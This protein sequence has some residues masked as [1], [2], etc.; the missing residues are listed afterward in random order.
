MEY[1][2]FDINKFNIIQD[3]ENYYFFRALNMADNND[4]EQG[5]TASEN[6]KIKRIRTD[7]E[8]FEGKT[9]YSKDSKISLEELYDHIKMHQRKDTNCISLT[10]NSNVAVNYGRSSYKDRYVMVKIPKKEFGNKT[11]SAGQFMLQEL[12]AKIQQTIENLPEQEKQELLDAFEII[13]NAKE[14]KTLQDIITRRY[15]AKKGEVATDNAHP[16]KG[17][18]YSSPKA[19]ISSYQALDEEQLLELNKV[20]AKLAI[21]ENEGILKHVIPHSTNSK[22]RETIGNAFSSTEVIHYGEIN[23]DNIIEI[24]K[25]IA[26]I[27]ALIQQVS[28]IEKS[29]IE[30]L[31]QALII[32]V[33]NGIRISQI[34]DI[35][36]RVKDNISIEEMYELT[37]GKV[38]YG[39]ANSIVKN[40]FYLSKSRQNAIVLS[41]TLKQLLGKNSGFEDIIEYIRD[42]GFRV[43]PEIISRKS[44]KGLVLSESVNL[45]L[46]D[47]EQLLVD[48]IKGLSPEELDIVLQNGGLYNAKDIIT[49]TF[50]TTGEKET[51]DKSRYYAEAIIARYNW[52][53]IGIEEF[54]IS[55]K[56]E[57]I[58]RLQERNCIEIYEK[59]KGAGVGEEKIPT[60]LLNIALR[61]TFYE[62]YEN[63]NLEELLNTRQ[64]VLKN[65]INIELVERFLGYYDVENTGIKLKDYQQRAYNNINKIFED[66]KFAQVILPTGAG[67]SFVALA[68]MQK[69]V[70]EHPNEKML[71]LAPQDEILNQIKK[72]I[73]N[74]VHEKKGTVGKTEDEI[75]SEIFPNITF[76]TYSGLLAKRCQKVVKDQYGMIIL[77]ELHRT[78]AKEWEGKVNQLLENQ[79][80]S[81]KVLGI[82]ATPTRDADGR[83]MA[84]ETAKKLGYTDKK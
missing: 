44:G 14:S 22:L 42:N 17:I 83:D 1:N 15:T 31:K 36:S 8:R 50:G 5:I 71:Y 54:T 56:N 65:S 2:L 49:R 39:K 69:Y 64:E 51:I 75:I 4:I 12:Y 3:E 55:E 33:Q 13:E 7:R 59:L 37:E 72:Y 47:E 16:R 24:P 60:A 35:T 21:L 84:N 79:K 48:E 10:T 25:E 18:K 77:D 19:R 68:Q 40:M 32:V 80:D 82:T 27:F 30:E 62:Q 66:K 38:E 43:E 73:V 67:K 46:Q 29:R 45:N 63:G 52:Q 9:K 28:G 20:Y 26:D 81:V 61:E 41:N 58:S 78:G 76:E 23:E 6:G 74:H 57:L 34:P 11:V 70:Q 53:E